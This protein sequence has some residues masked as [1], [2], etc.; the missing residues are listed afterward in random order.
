MTTIAQTVLDSSM[1]YADYVRRVEELWQNGHTSTTGFNNGKTMMQYTADNLGRMNRLNKNIVLGIE[2]I[3][4]LSKITKPIILLDITE[5]WCGDASQVCP[6]V[7]KI[8]QAQPLLSHCVIFR[9]EHLD[10]MDSFLT[11][12]GRSIP[13]IIALD[14]EGVVL[15][16]WGPRP[17]VLQDLV[18]SH[19][20]DMLQMSKEEQKVHYFFVRDLVHNWYDSDETKETQ[21]ELAN[22]L[23]KCN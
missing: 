11:D 8:A 9:D 12:E 2:T 17:K 23:M 19:K 10:I 22:F 18:Q 14:T 5:G 7:E 16:A 13:K 1:T 4:K 20:K 15:G 6:V 21:R 3:E